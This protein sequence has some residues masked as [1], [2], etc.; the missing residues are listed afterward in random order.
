[1][2][3]AVAETVSMK[4]AARPVLDLRCGLHRLQNRNVTLRYL[5]ERACEACFAQVCIMIRDVS[6]STMHNILIGQNDH[7]FLKTTNML[8]FVQIYGGLKS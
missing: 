8:V 6:Y 1:M 7:C 4:I 5:E 2:F 3:Q